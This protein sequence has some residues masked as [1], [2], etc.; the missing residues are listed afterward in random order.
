MDD[1]RFILMVLDLV[2]ARF[3]L[4]VHSMFFF[5]LQVGLRSGCVLLGFVPLPNLL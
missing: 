3:G 2:F 5:R 1:H 4:V